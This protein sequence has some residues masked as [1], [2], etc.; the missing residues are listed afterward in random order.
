MTISL[1]KVARRLA[2]QVFGPLPILTALF[3][4]FT[5]LQGLNL[6]PGTSPFCQTNSSAN[7]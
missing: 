5:E 1:V 7:W 2:K 3:W 4:S 6:I